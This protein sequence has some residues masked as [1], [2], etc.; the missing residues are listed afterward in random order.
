[1]QP[2]GPRGFLSARRLTGT[3]GRHCRMWRVPPRNDWRTKEQCAGPLAGRGQSFKRRA[4]Q[5]CNHATMPPIRTGNTP[6]SGP[7]AS[8]HWTFVLRSLPQ[9]SR[10]FD[11][12]HTNRLPTRHPT[13]H[14][15]TIKLKLSQ[16]SYVSKN[17]M[18]YISPS[19]LVERP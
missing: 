6:D 12:F 18:S 9:W 4:R 17:T 11:L 1:M 8:Y 19:I 14:W 13:L 2:T 10:C 16:Q 15:V 7:M 3:A 5:P